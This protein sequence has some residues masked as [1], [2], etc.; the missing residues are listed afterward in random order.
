VGISLNN[1][2]ERS[3]IIDDIKFAFSSRTIIVILAISH[4]VRLVFHFFVLPNSPSGF[5]PDEGT[6][7]ALA[8]HVAQGL[9]VEEFPSYGANLY[10][11]A[12]SIMLPSALLVELGIDELS[13]VRTIASIYG[14]A[15]SLV[16]VLCFLAVLKLSSQVFDKPDTVFDRKFLTLLLVFTFF[17][18]N[19]VWSTIGLRESGSQFWLMTTFYLI[20]KLLDSTRRDLLKFTGL[21]SLSLT[22]AYG[23]RPETALVFSVIALVTSIVLLVKFRKVF[24]LIT[25]LLGVFAGQAFTTTPVTLAEES[26]GAFQIVEQGLNQSFTPKP[27]ES[28]QSAT[29]KPVESNQSATPK[30]V[31]SNQS[32]TPKPVE[33][34]QSATPKPV[35]SN[36]SA[37]PKPVESNRSATPKPVESNQSATPKPVESNQSA[38]PKPVESNQSAT[39]KPVE[40]LVGKRNESVSANCT[41]ENQIIQF[42][43]QTFR[44]KTSKSYQVEERDLTKNLEQQILTAQI[45][46]YKRNVNAL[47]A[48]SALPYSTCQNLSR[49]ILTLIECNLKELPY[50]LF[51]FLFRPLIFFDQGSATLNFAALENLGWMILVPLSVLI[52]LGRRENSVDRFINLGLT[53]YVL[54]FASAAALYEGNLGT[55][56][57][58]KSTILWPLIFILM[59]APRILPK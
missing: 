53:S 19:F 3:A 10:N 58:H 56:F 27:V 38:T 23:T 29:P 31:E 33:S 17:P 39:P 28:N 21:C 12:K 25:I 26:L 30:P 48:Q 15:S 34:N 59:L 13:S 16:L 8:K 37:T 55:A 14:L 52:S 36:Q 7:A 54:L 40:S 6:Y 4:L 35:E 2:L 41:Q 57:R 18:S 9:P 45:L 43:G 24:P 5:G 47:E 1:S 44:C 51:A 46:E 42:E 50:R 11:S 20:L 22:L 49:D 32:A